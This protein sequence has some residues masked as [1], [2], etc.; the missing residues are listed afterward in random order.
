MPDETP[1]V[2]E[3]TETIMTDTTVPSEDNI[4]LPNE[5]LEAARAA[6]AEVLKRRV[7]KAKVEDL[8]DP[9]K[10]LLKDNDYANIRVLEDSGELSD[11]ISYLQTSVPEVGMYLGGI[12][13]LSPSGGD[14]ASAL[15]DDAKINIIKKGL[16]ARAESMVPDYNMPPP[17]L[18]NEIQEAR[19]K[20]EDAYSRYQ[21]QY[22]QVPEVAPVFRGRSAVDNPYY[23]Q[24]T[25]G[26]PIFRNPVKKIRIKK[27]RVTRL[28]FL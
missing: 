11:V 3:P 7:I 9:L 8:L 21:M 6:E 28:K 23:T 19:G 13:D 4:N 10:P 20:Q 24:P 12:S 25:P 26:R 18:G 1:V 14:A 22:G 5:Q 27:G 17:F 2:E 16:K 15:D